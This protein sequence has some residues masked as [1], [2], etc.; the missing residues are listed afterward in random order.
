MGDEEASAVFSIIVA[1]C[2]IVF[3]IL[4]VVVPVFLQ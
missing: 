2:A 4:F 1:A 3:F